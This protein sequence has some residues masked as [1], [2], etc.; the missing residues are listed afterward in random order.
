MRTRWIGS[1]VA[2]AALLLGV[3]AGAVTAAAQEATPEV[4]SAPHPAHIHEGTC[5]EL[6]DVVY[7]LN[8]VTGEI[9]SGTPEATP[10]SLDDA[11]S[12][13]VIGDSETEVDASLDDLT[14]GE[15]AVNVHKS[16]EEIDVFIACADVSGEVE[17]GVLI[18][19]LQE[20][21]DSGVKGQVI[22]NDLG[23][24][25]TL[26]RVTLTDATPPEATPAS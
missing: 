22:L 19:D 16:A 18:I 15:H 1:T 11:E 7:P 13:S 5:E 8:D 26:V 3:I 6:G 24:G 23:D 2:I 17:D 21:N 14:S 10:V 4:D 25:K 20:L 9:L 12:G